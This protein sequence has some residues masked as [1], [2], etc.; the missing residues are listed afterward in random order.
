MD[1]C[2]MGEYLI[3]FTPAGTDGAGMALY[4]RNP[5]G[6]PVNVA[7]ACSRL[8]V[9]AGV[10][11][12][13]S[14]DPFGRFLTDYLR[15]L[16]NVDMRG[17]KVK[18]GPTGLAF[19]TLDGDGERDFA[20][21]RGGCADTLLTPED[22]DDELIEECRV[23][24]FSSVS[25]ARGSSREATFHAARRA[26]ELGKTVSFDINHRPPLWDSEEE[27]A[28]EVEKA[29]RLADIV[30]ASEEEAVMFGG[31]A[32]GCAERFRDL[33]AP[34]TLVTFGEGGS[35]YDNG[36]CRGRVP[37]FPVKAVDTTGA[38]DCFMGAFLSRFI[39]SGRRPEELCGSE[40]E[41]MLRFANA[42]G[43][44]CATGTGAIAPQPSESE[45]M[46]L[47]GSGAPRPKA[48]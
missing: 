15:D 1:L 38:G 14:S 21:F 43:A 11:T 8:G 31:S 6:A 30:K 33:G 2:V 13:V 47:L 44:L 7:C 4:A 19:V 20:F 12:G 28:R 45:V 26:K 34:L 40:L 5:G 18:D 10:I 16:G 29:L 27:A 39:L 23:F 24:H 42:A 17:V 48:D 37:S 25:L 3:D 46:S 22:I 35:S 36:A 41:S 32:E 9:P